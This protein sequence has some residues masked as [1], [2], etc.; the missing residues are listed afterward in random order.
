LGSGEL[1]HIARSTRRRSLFA[2]DFLSC[3]E[4]TSPWELYDI[5]DRFRVPLTRTAE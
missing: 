5:E 3:A 4:S 1:F 2:L